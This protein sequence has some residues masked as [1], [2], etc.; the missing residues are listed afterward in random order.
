[1]GRLSDFEVDEDELVVEFRKPGR[2]TEAL[3]YR[4]DGYMTVDVEIEGIVASMTQLHQGK[5]SGNVG[6]L[7]IDLVALILTI[8]A[9]GGLTLWTTLPARRS[10][11]LASL[12]AGVVLAL[13]VWWYL[14]L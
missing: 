9:V 10:V 7:M 5:R 1:M 6:S 12:A 11:G 2:A 14:V 8:T 4:D 3:I 13:G